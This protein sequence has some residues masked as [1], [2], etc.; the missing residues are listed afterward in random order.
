M[1]DNQPKKTVTMKLIA[2][3]NLTALEMIQDL[4]PDHKI[5]NMRI[6][7]N[8]QIR[9]EKVYTIDIRHDNKKT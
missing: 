3:S 7:N 2:G 8:Y 5:V 1:L 6:D 9:H 4:W